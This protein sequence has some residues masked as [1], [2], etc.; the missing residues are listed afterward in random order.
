MKEK[1][2]SCRKNKEKVKSQGGNGCL[3]EVEAILDERKSKNNESEFLVK[4][5][6]Y[7]PEENSWEPIENLR[8]C[9]YLLQK[10]WNS[11]IKEKNKSKKR[12]AKKKKQKQKIIQT[13]KKNH[14]IYHK[15]KIN[16]D[17][18]SEEHLKKLSWVKL[19][20]KNKTKLFK[21]T[22]IY[23]SSGLKPLHIYDL[24]NFIT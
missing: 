6:N 13:Q 20:R 17:I 11:K 22:N 18:I 1:K 7:P 10:F 9:Q 15:P 14:K 2:K 4:W 8:R 5:R 19:P 3:F 12:V 21:A 24:N 16:Y 23:K